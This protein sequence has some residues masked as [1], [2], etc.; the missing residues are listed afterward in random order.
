MWQDGNIFR[1][2]E[3]RK[4]NDIQIY[5]ESESGTWQ[6]SELIS[7]SMLQDGIIFRKWE[8]KESNDIPKYWESA[9]EE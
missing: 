5:S 3:W 4:S 6:L 2:W 9:S 1:K 8:W 7:E